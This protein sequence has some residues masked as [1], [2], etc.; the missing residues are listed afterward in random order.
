MSLHCEQYRILHKALLKLRVR[1][2]TVIILRYF[3][4][5]TV[6]EI[7]E[8]TGAKEGTIKSQLH[9]GLAQLQDI[10]VRRGML[11]E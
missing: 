9:R 11:P 8:I 1:Y 2:R 6:A 5:K 3:E 7:S 4:D 10:L